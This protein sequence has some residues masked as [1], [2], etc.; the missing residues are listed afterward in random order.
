MNI[1]KLRANTTKM[2]IYTGVT[3]IIIAGSIYS[4]LFLYNNFYKTLASSQKIKILREEWNVETSN[5]RSF[6]EI[7]KQME[8]KS[9]SREEEISIDFN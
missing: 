5:I 2:I 8:L 6:Q 4:A 7:K 3:L 9:K 1:K